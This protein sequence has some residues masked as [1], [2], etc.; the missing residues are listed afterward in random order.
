MTMESR[1]TDARTVIFSALEWGYFTNFESASLTLTSVAIFLPIGTLAAQRMT[2]SSANCSAASSNQGGSHNGISWPTWASS[3]VPV[4]SASL[5]NS[6]GTGGATP[7]VS[8]L[9]RCEGGMSPSRE[10]IDPTDLELMHIDMN[11]DPAGGRVRVER[12]LEQHFDRV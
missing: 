3:T 11:H 1:V 7:Q 8:I 9:S 5:T 10:R 6:S 4:K 2:Q 12:D